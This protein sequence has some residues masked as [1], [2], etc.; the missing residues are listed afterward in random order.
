M[1]G[2]SKDELVTGE[3]DIT[4]LFVTDIGKLKIYV[5]GT[6]KN[7]E[8]TLVTYQYLTEL[9][10]SQREILVETIELNHHLKFI[11]PEGVEWNDQGRIPDSGRVF[12][13][14]PGPLQDGTS[15]WGGVGG[16]AEG[17]GLLQD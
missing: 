17:T 3:G 16:V 5:G 12:H 14:G 1:G 7:P 9:P 15:P 13:G 10:P 2:P 8:G 6:E 4:P 11:F